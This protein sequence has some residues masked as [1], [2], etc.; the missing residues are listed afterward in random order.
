MLLHLVNGKRANY[1]WYYLH[2]ATDKAKKVVKSFNNNASKYKDV[3]EII[4]KRWNI[5]L[6]HPLHAT[7][8][9]LNPKGLCNNPHTKFVN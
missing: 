9:I 1:A 4:D 7:D 5:Q 8:H 3:F 6:H 2:K